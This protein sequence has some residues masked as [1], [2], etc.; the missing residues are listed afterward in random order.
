MPSNLHFFL[1]HATT[2]YFIAIFRIFVLN[3]QRIIQNGNCNYDFKT[4]GRILGNPDK[5]LKNFPPSYSQS[6][7]QLCLRFL[8]LQ[9]H[10]TSYSFCKGERRTP[11]RKP[12]PLP[13]G[14]LNPYRNLKSENSQ[15]YSQKPQI[16]CMFMNWASGNKCYT[17]V[18]EL[19]SV[20]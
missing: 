5:S 9:P 12:N 4:R 7:L 8:F 2:N 10:A 15:D 13:Y 3:K 11:D 19:T 18:T 17:V 20:F 6:P 1:I 14:L 16:D